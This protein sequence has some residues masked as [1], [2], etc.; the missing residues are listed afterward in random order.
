MRKQRKNFIPVY[1]LNYFALPA[2]TYDKQD[3]I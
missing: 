2:A 1:R 3:I